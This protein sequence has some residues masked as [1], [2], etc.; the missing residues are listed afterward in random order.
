[1]SDGTA[2]INN[3]T[4]SRFDNE[5]YRPDDGTVDVAT[6]GSANQ[7]TGVNSAAK[8]PNAAQSET[9]GRISKRMSS[10]PWYISRS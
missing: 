9:T 1:M 6:C 8:D 2:T 4:N 5:E 7:V 3:V 10:A